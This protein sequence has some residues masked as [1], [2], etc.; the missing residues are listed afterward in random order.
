MLD[1]RYLTALQMAQFV[2]VFV[3]ALLP[4]Y[5]TCDYPIIVTKVM[6]TLVTLLTQFLFAYRERSFLPMRLKHK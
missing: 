5:Y 6:A 1:D 2:L 3:H 4:L